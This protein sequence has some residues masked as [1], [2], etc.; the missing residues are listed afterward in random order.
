MPDTIFRREQ[1][2]NSTINERTLSLIL[3]DIF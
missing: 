3:N 1:W 2:Y